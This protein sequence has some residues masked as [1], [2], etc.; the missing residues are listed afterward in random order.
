MSRNGPSTMKAWQFSSTAGG[1]EANLKLSHK[2]DP[3]PAKLSSDEVFVEVISMSLNPVDYKVAELP[4]VGRFAIT[5][6]ASPGLDYCGRVI[7]TGSAVD[8]KPGQIVF[9]RLD[10]PSKFGS[11]AECIVVKRAGAVLLPNGV[12]PD[13]AAAIGTAGLTAYQ[14]IVPYVKAGDKVFINGGS[15]G[16]GTF[17]VQIAK[18]VGCHVTTS[19]SSQNI[20]LCKDLGADEVIDYK[21]TD[22]VKELR[23]RAHGFALI[24]DN[25]GSPSR[26]YEDSHH[27]LKE[28]GR[29]VQVGVASSLSGFFS[30]FTRSFW[31]SFLGGGKRPYSFILVVNKYDDFAQIA[32]WMKEGKVRAVIDT[33]FEFEEGNKS[34]DILKS[35]R[36]RGKIVVR[37]TEKS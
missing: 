21:S 36:A 26:L 35:G 12:D 1:I 16:T 22:L 24:V 11:L 5:K 32:Q 17:G 27:Y 6:P 31:P 10:G 23:A 33:V 20:Q 29:Y 15:G 2:A 7:G 30:L 34:F 19:C 14:S 37:V 25:V 8:V 18:A 4:V 3:P 13:H 9:G 28:G